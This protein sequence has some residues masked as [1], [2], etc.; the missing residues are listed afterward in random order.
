[1]LAML[2]F[3]LAQGQGLAADMNKDQQAAGVEGTHVKGTS[4]EHASTEMHIFGAL[5][6]LSLFGAWAS[7]TQTSWESP[8]T[9]GI[10]P[11]SKPSCF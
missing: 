4:T 11:S 9:W 7:P 5:A 2:L 8:S 6:V 1:L 3:G 10:C